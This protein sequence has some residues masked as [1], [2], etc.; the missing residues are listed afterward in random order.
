MEDRFQGF[1]IEDGDIDDEDN[2]DAVTDNYSW[3]FQNYEDNVDDTSNDQ[4][5]LVKSFDE[6][7]I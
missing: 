4:Y 7:S 5:K 2:Q 1:E 6:F 3:M